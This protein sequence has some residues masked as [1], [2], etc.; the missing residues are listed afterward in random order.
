MRKNLLYLLLILG[1]LSCEQQGPQEKLEHLN[2]YWEIDRVEFSKDS[3][4]EFRINETVDYIELEN[5]KGFRT[6]VRP[7]FDGSFEV[8]GDI[9]SLKAKTEGGDL[10]LLYSTPFDT[11]KEKVLQADENSV[12][13]KNERDIIYHYKRYEPLLSNLDETK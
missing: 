4:K 5:G 1:G 12:S 10:Y 6:K 11:W 9:D 7:R 8:S 3:I 13:I 2:G